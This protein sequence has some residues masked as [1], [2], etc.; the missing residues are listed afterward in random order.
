MYILVSTWFGR[1]PLLYPI[2]NSLFNVDMLIAL[3]NLRAETIIGCRT[4]D[5]STQ[6]LMMQAIR[7]ATHDRRFDVKISLDSFS[8]ESNS[9]TSSVTHFQ[10]LQMMHLNCGHLLQIIVI[11]PD[12]IHPFFPTESGAYSIE[13]S[14][15]AATILAPLSV[16]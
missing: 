6:F 11:S 15:K 14:F 8:I 4:G 10:F 5:L 12:H 7:C 1:V 13:H 3:T 16:T 9:C 2:N